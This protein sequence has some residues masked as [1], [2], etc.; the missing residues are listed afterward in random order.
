ISPSTPYARE[1]NLPGEGRDGRGLGAVV[2]ASTFV[3][4]SVG[5]ASREEA[6]PAIS[7]IP[8]AITIRGRVERLGLI[9]VMGRFSG[10]CNS[11]PALTSQPRGCL[12]RR[13]RLVRSPLS[14]RLVG[15]HDER[16]VVEPR[17]HAPESDLRGFPGRDLDHVDGVAVLVRDVAPVG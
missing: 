4:G 3:L 6:H 12:L 2:P 10:S 9:L 11:S 13:A 5:P 1:P 17:G 8:T 15:G 7:T 16:V 14:L